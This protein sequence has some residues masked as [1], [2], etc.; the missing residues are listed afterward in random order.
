MPQVLTVVAAAD[1]T[2]AAE[3]IRELLEKL[4]HNGIDVG[5]KPDWLS[6][7][8]AVD[9]PVGHAPVAVVTKQV[10]ETLPQVDKAVQPDAGRRKKLLLAD[11]DS[12]MVQSES[13]DELAEFLGFGPQVKAITER[14]MRGEL[15]FRESLRARVAL[16]EGQPVGALEETLKDI[17]YTRGAETAVRTMAAHGCYTILVSG[18][19][20]FTTTVVHEKLGFHTHRANNF[21]I[22]DGK[23]TG[24]VVEPILGRDSKLETLNE[25]CT[26]L[27]LSHAE[28]CT[29]GDGAN[30][31]D[32]LRA[33]GLGVAYH[34][35]PIVRQQAPY[36]INHGDM[37]TLLYFQGY[38]DSEFVPEQRT[39]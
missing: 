38:R 30:D 22:A 23:L 21:E 24:R 3:S 36:Q 6:P 39:V 4:D 10:E 26:K 27:D 9:I 28:T 5:A 7:G 33:A 37:T 17:P 34:G 18:G 12:T 29:V 2:L 32:M 15:D 31:L 11:M 1:D 19:F 25:F 13:L 8:R 14:S 20:E 16:L 35:K